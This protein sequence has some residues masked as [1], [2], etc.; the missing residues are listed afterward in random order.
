MNPALKTKGKFSECKTITKQL[1]ALTRPDQISPV[2]PKL[3]F[4]KQ[5]NL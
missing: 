3:I 2:L 1:P 5:R 4:Q